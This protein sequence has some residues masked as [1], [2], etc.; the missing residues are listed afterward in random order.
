MGSLRPGTGIVERGRDKVCL[1]AGREQTPE[2]GLYLLLV[3]IA[4]T[5]RLIARIIYRLYELTEEKMAV[6]QRRG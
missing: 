1:N 3:C 4:A 2:S 5:D 6:V